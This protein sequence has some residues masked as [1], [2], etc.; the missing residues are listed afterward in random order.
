MRDLIIVGAGGMGRSVYNTALQCDGY[1]KEYRI[2]GFIDDNL[3][4]L[5]HYE[6]YPPIIGRILDYE[7]KEN[8]V[9]IN[10]LGDIENKRK[11]I[12]CLLGRGADFIT[13]IHPAAI[14]NRNAELGIGCLVDSSSVIGA[15]V[16]IGDFVVVGV[17]TVVGHDVRIG[18]W[19]RIDGHV[20]LVGGV[21][22]DE[23]VCVHTGAIINH[24]VRLEKRSCV[25][26][27]SFVIKKVKEATTV[28]GNPARQLL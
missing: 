13:L 6:G 22:V 18:S 23:E 27:G 8:D 10:A 17:G 9:F 19:S 15:D 28:Y 5:S 26:A 2:K 3:F 1:D 25:G 12:E 16:T 14:V 20:T 11:C 24:N 4:S 7:I 21:Q